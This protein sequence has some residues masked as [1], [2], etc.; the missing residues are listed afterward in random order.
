MSLEHLS[1]WRK[2]ALVLTLVSGILMILGG[3]LAYRIMQQ[4]HVQEIEREMQLINKLQSQNVYTWRHA[5]LT[6]ADLLTGAP[7]FGEAIANWL[8]AR[9]ALDTEANSWRAPILSQLRQ[10]TEQANY[11]AVYLLDTSG[12]VLLSPGSPRQRAL[13]PQ[14]QLALEQALS[15]ARAAT[16]EPHR[17]PS[18]AF[19]YFSLVAPI[20]LNDEP[21]AAVWMVM[22]VRKSLFPLV[23]QW[24]SASRTAESAIVTRD[25]S[26]VR[27][28]SPLH[29][30]PEAA[31]RFRISSAHQQD[32][33]VLAASGMRGL[34]EGTDYRDQPVIAVASPVPGSPW[35]LVSKID[36][37]EALH[38]RTRDAWMILLPVLAG[39]LCIWLALAYVQH[40]AWRQER[41]LKELLERQ[42]RHDPLTQL[43]NRVALNERFELNWHQ[44][45]RKRQPLSV[46]MIDVD[47]FKEYNDHFGHVSGDH[48]LKRIADILAA[49]TR[50]ATDLAAR[51]GGEEF[52][53]LL[54]DTTAERAWQLARQLCQAVHEAEIPHPLS[55]HD[56]RVTISIGLSTFVADHAT[57][58]SSFT[59]VRKAMLE[60]A[61]A[62]LYEAKRAGRNQVAMAP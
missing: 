20:Y 37:A 1:P 40:L 30:Q 12:R 45:L 26:G 5:R 60:Q 56:Q 44:A 34:F 58:G 52:V 53:I 11:D 55:R 42:V 22:D 25:G 32:P 9:A 10:L 23:D 4:R 28:L 41:L 33:M 17:D 15:Q 35:Y 19:P 29:D 24:P 43:A 6:E 57:A 61:D 36:K 2:S 51:Y 14:E 59:K 38:S 21:I 48:C 46:L 13:P 16:V 7:L 27:L 31:L 39:L 50:R 47:H 49:A 62:A 8:H 3:M 54:P 18:F